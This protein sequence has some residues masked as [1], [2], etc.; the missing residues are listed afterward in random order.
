RA[1]QEI[2]FCIQAASIYGLAHFPDKALALLNR[3]EE[4]AHRSN[5]KER[6]IS[7]DYV[8]GTVYDSY[9]DEKATYYYKLAW[10]G[11]NQTEDHPQRGF[12]LYILVDYF[13]R[14]GNAIE[15]SKFAEEFAKYKH[16]AA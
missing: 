11:I 14:S 9:D 8:R 16:R 4:I 15:L 12:Y 5:D 10:D 3:A 7:I 13:S 2:G 6:R 1:R